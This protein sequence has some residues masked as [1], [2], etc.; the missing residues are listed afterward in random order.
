MVGVLKPNASI[1]ID[2]YVDTCRYTC[3]QCSWKINEISVS[4]IRAA[5]FNW[6][7]NLRK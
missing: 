6:D 5:S 2:R 4:I 1:L 3:I 7:L